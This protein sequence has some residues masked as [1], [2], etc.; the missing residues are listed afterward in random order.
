M[1]NLRAVALLM[2]GSLVLSG[3][4]LIPT[5]A[6]PTASSSHEVPFGLLDKTIPGTKN[7]TVTF[8][9]SYLYWVTP[10]DSLLALQRVTPSP[11]NP[12]YVLN[13]LTAGPN[14]QEQSRH[15][16]SAIPKKLAIT[17]IQVQDGLG[18]LTFNESLSKMPLKSE[19]LALGQIALSAEGVGATLGIIVSVNGV[20]QLLPLPNGSRSLLVSGS[21]FTALL[22]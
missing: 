6:K 12:S 16:S 20:T 10:K 21:D 8:T 4:T 17:S 2:V 5:S 13:A 11:A 22:K 1:K 19:L 7:A 14:P 9:T 3:C 18:Y 15:L